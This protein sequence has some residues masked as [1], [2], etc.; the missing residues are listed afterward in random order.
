[1]EDKTVDNTVRRPRLVEV[2]KSEGLNNTRLPAPLGR[3]LLGRVWVLHFP[4]FKNIRARDAADEQ[5]SLIF[6]FGDSEGIHHAGRKLRVL[7]D[8]NP[9]LFDAFWIA[10]GGS[11]ADCKFPRKVNFFSPQQRGQDLIELAL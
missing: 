9:E 11:Q 1:M 2:R 10:V 6:L 4:S 8:K 5:A 3:N 7:I